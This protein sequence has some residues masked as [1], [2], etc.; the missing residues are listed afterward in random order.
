MGI[1]IYAFV[2]IH[3]YIYIR[4]CTV[5]MYVYVRMKN[6]PSYSLS[7]QSSLLYTHTTFSSALST[8]PLSSTFLQ[9][10]T[11]PLFL[12]IETPLSLSHLHPFPFRDQVRQEKRK[13][14]SHI[15]SLKFLDKHIESAVFSGDFQ[16]LWKNKRDVLEVFTITFWLLF[17]IFSF[18]VYFC[19]FFISYLC[20]LW[21]CIVYC[22]YVIFYMCSF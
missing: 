3:T 19:F 13:N 5:R 20:Y 8:Y 4:T 1:Y 21:R 2:C 6:P 16:L 14:R 22:S 7:S 18:L 9:F 17:L 11:F 15:S 10:S 12:F